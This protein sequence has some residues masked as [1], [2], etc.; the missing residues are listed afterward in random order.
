MYY[1]K[2]VSEPDGR[3]NVT[4][5]DVPEAITYGETL[6]EALMHARDALETALEIYEE[7]GIEFPEAKYRSKYPVHP[8]ML[9]AAK[10]ELVRA[11]KAERMTKYKLGKLLKLHP[12]QV[13]RLVSIKHRTRM[14]DVERALAAVGRK[15]WAEFSLVSG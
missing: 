4:F 5:P 6:G 14:E 2:M 1:A 9:V 11:M 10:L 12:P 3:V 7:E 13:D 8:R 15:V